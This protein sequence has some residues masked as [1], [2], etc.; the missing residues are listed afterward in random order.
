MYLML[1]TVVVRN[2]KSVLL[3]SLF[4]LLF[5]ISF[6][7]TENDAL[8]VK[9]IYNEVLLNGESY[10]WLE[11]LCKDVG[12]R[13]TGSEGY[14]KAVK[15]AVESLEGF[16]DTVFTQAVEV[17]Y[18]QRG[19]REEVFAWIGKEKIKLR[20]TSLGNCVSTPIEGIQ[21]E[22]IEVFSL[23][24][25]NELGDKV[26]GKIVFFN[27]PMDPTI[28][29]T[30]AGYGGAVDQRVFGAAT[31][32]KY[33]ARAVLV[34]SVTTSLDTFAHTGTN[35]YIDTIPA[36]PAMAISTVDA[37]MLSEAL[38]KEP[39]KVQLFNTSKMV[40]KRTN[41]NVIAELRGKVSPDTIIVIG[42]HLDSWDLA[43]G[44]HDD[45][46]G[47]AHMVGVMQTLHKMK[48]D[49]RY[50]VRCVLFANEENGLAGGTGYAQRSEKLNEKHIAA[51]ESDGGGFSPRGFGCAGR[52]DIFRPY[53]ASLKSFE[54]VLHPFGI[55]IDNGGGGADIGPLK[56]QGPLLIGLQVDNQRYF[57]YHHT[58]QDTFDKVNKRQLDLGV[59]AITS[60]VYLID[61]HGL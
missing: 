20:S 46:T 47:C 45:G 23:D 26:K 21:G 51:I 56:P 2:S 39:V 58:K 11:K 41:H 4:V 6:S 42:G 55:S 22:I 10:Y 60:L 25:V 8:E 15:Y 14:D 29:N 28:I 31:A 44:A 61:K 13:L 59:A 37:N 19:N 17:N 50:T 16:C 5:N 43:Q 52:E 35:M 9:K 53:F 54:D 36:I 38:K 40:G 57:D 30:G 12:P 48:I 18:W 3:T 34:R 7:Q 1:L 24:E 27:R 49:T 33:G 32:G